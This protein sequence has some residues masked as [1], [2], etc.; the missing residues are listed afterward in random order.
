MSRQA[1][2]VSSAGAPIPYIRVERLG[3]GKGRSI[4]KLLKVP[5]YA[6]IG[7]CVELWEYGVD[8]APMGNDG[9]PDLRGHLP[10]SPPP[11]ELLAAVLEWEGDAK[12]LWDALCT[13]GLC[14][15]KK[16]STPAR[17]KGLKRYAAV[18]KERERDRLR[19]RNERGAS[20]PS[21]FRRVS[22]GTPAGVPGVEEDQEEDQEEDLD[23]LKEEGPTLP[24]TSVASPAAPSS[25][26]FFPWMRAQRIRRH[27]ELKEE[28]PPPEATLARLAGAEREVG[29]LELEQRYLAYLEVEYWSTGKPPWHANGFGKTWPSYDPG[30]KQLAIAEVPPPP[31]RCELGEPAAVGEYRQVLEQLRVEGNAYAVSQLQQLRPELRDGQLHLVAA[32]RFFCS[33]VV[34][35]YAALIS[36]KRKHLQLPPALFISEE[37][38]CPG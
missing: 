33:W 32:D 29:R 13:F 31:P 23:L 1:H 2:N 24:I 12:K 6:G 5:A 37:A 22:G 9:K 16:G 28:S 26:G 15:P 8:S 30:P 7:L 19:K 17:I 14:E 34:D 10:S 38:L 3:S 11:A 20:T 4:A 35:H 18:F 25:V 27:P 36:A 21:G